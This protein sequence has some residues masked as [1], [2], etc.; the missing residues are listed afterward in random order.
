M[1]DGV[2]ERFKLLSYNVHRGRSAFRRRDIT[3]S[4]AEILDFSSADAVCLQEVWRDEGFDVHRFEEHTRARWDH[5]V[6]AQTAA[7][8]RGVQGNAVLSRMPV[9]AWRHFDVSIPHREPRGLLQATLQPRGGSREVEL[10]CV[11]FGLK[12]TERRRQVELLTRF[13]DEHI[14]PD[15]PLFIA[16]DFNDWRCELTG[17]FERG[18]GMKEVMCEAGGKLGRTYPA[19][20]PFL[21]LDRIYFRNGR[22]KRARIVRDRACLMLSDH[23]PIEAEFEL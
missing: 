1:S 8:R 11:H 22:L 13:I 21:P 23:L 12:A 18:L 17:A 6:F 4:V 9:A 10:F 2:G 3:A 14:A 7:F 15:A 16:G 19:L 20:A 5:R